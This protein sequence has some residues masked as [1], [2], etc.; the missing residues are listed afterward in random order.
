MIFCIRPGDN[1]NQCAQGYS[2]PPPTVTLDNFSPISNR[3]FDVG[4]GGPAPFTFTTTSNVPWLTL[5]P[6]K[7]SISP[8]APEQR[9]VASVNDWSKLAA[10]ANTAQITFVATTKGQPSLS[11]TATL[12]ATRN[13]PAPGFKGEYIWLIY[14]EQQ[15]SCRHI[16]GFV[17]GSGVISI[18]AAHATRKSSAQG[19]SWTELQGLG[20]TLSG[21][22]P[23]PDFDNNFAVGTG[24]TL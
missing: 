22:T 6:A 4:A 5:S 15:C 11:V 20:R 14:S 1:P 8:D 24:P 18:E 3:Y 12:I 17:E 13:T 7:G 19:I 23:L 2:C 10:G 21:V 16:A 9:V